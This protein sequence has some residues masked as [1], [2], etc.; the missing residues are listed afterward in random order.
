I[1][2][3]TPAFADLDGDGDLDLVVGYDDGTLSYYENV[4]SAASPSYEAVTGSANPFDGIDVGDDNVDYHS[5]PALAD[6]DGDGDLDLV[7]GEYWGALFYYENVGSAASPTYSAVTGNASPFDDVDVGRNS[8]PALGDLDGDGDLDL[9][10][11]VMYGALLYYENVGNATSPSYEAAIENPFD[12]IDVGLHSAP[13]LGDLDAD[14]DLDLV[15]GEEDGALYYYENAGSG[16]SPSYM[17]VTGTRNP[18]DGID[19]GVR[20]GDLYYYEIEGPA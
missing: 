17:A 8:A 6:L 5:M 11:G 2:G 9:V 15:V 7:V 3:S 10:V 12:G 19:G 1:V 4:G 16:A 14:G 13:A 18:F 20:N